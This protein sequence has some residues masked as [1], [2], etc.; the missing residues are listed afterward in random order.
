[1]HLNN[2]IRKALDILQKDPDAENWPVI[3]FLPCEDVYSPFAH[4]CASQLRALFQEEP[5]RRVIARLLSLNPKP[6]EMS[7]NEPRDEKYRLYK[8]YGLD[9]GGTYFAEYLIGG[10]PPQTTLRSRNSV[11]P[12][13]LMENV[14]NP[15]GF[16]NL[17]QE[18]LQQSALQIT[19][20]KTKKTRKK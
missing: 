1:M 13:E 19:G 9:Q 10:R 5:E 17:I 12:E 4:L 20:K 11:T 7:S 2:T 3:D 18:H 16:L 15:R 8:K 6:V 14:M